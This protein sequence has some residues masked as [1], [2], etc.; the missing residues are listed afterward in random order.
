M[1]EID[2]N[3]ISS[4]LSNDASDA[5]HNKYALTKEPMAVYEQALVS[6]QTY[7]SSYLK[8]ELYK[9]RCLFLSYLLKKFTS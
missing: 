5:P 7:T 1:V 4:Y 9:K 8:S 2:E 6:K 3:D